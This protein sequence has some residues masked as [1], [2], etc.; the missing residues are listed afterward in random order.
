MNI[1]QILSLSATFV[2]K[3]V[4][5]KKKVLEKISEIMAESIDCSPKQIFESLH[6][7]ERLGS[8]SLGNGIAI[9]HGRVALCDKPT[10]VFLMLEE[11][12]DYDS[13]DKLP[14]DII[15]A[16]MV[17]TKAHQDHLRYLAQIAE[18]L[19]CTPIASQIRHA[20]SCEV[21]YEI[22]EE[23]ACRIQ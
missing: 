23:A 20:H 18:V 15:F 1:S 13:P 14:V 7:R 12:V 22:L 5:S 10:A 21:L 2:Y 4:S 11:A 9:P 19:S 16:I 3:K 17:P 8:T 6:S